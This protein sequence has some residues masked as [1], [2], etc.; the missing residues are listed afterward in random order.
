MTYEVFRDLVG[1]ADNPPDPQWPG[2]AKLAVQFVLNY[3]EGGE[4][5]VLNGDAGSEVYLTEVPG[6]QP[7]IGQ[8]D[9]STPGV[10]DRI[11]EGLK[12]RK[13]QLLRTAYLT[14][15]RTDADVVN[16][17]ARRIVEGQGK[18]PGGQAAAPA[19]GK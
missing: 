10:S 16:Y 6:G 2:G 11:T 7:L 3:E 13:E 4:N 9:L 15:A 12:A 19:A 14:A 17:L 5:T 18:L 1:Y 8:R